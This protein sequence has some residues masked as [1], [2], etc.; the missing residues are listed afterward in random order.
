MNS[1]SWLEGI[2]PY[3]LPSDAYEVYAM[4]AQEV[5][6]PRYVKIGYSRCTEA[7]I[8]MVQT[9]CPIPLGDVYAFPCAALRVRQVEKA[10]HRRF[11]Q[12]R[13]VGEWFCVPDDSFVLEALAEASRDNECGGVRRLQA[14]EASR[15][16]RRKQKAARRR[17]NVAAQPKRNM[18]LPAPYF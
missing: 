1:E 6:G 18:E 15:E 8:G 4:F 11:A 10:L 3:F 2:D 17:V 9:G 5:S 14:L 7:R 16:H 13:T 12:F